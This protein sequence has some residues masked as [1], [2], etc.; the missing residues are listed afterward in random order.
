MCEE[1]KSTAY[2]VNMALAWL[3]SF[4][5]MKFKEKTYELLNKKALS[6]FVQNKAICKCRDSFRVDK[7]DKENLIKFRIK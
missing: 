7:T 2:Y 5:F 1:V 3:I 6:K 4:A